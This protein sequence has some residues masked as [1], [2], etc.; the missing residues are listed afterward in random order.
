MIGSEPSLA[1]FS[2]QPCQHV[3]L[4]PE[5][6]AAT[7][8]RKFV[9]EAVADRAGVEVAAQVA[10]LTSE[11]VTNAVVHA[12]TPIELG[13]VQDDDRILVA[14][15]D[16]RSAPPK[17]PEHRPER[18]G[19]RGLWLVGQL[20]DT[21]GVTAYEKGKSVWFTIRCATDRVGGGRR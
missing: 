2:E 4:D 17:V 1:R 8:A 20:S 14:V 16:R 18:A 3:A 15:G 19:G 21:W 13:V 5:P 12:R 11:L 9:A 6:R 10:L 7:E